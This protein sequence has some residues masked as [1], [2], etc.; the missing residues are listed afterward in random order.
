MIRFSAYPRRA[1]AGLF[2]RWARHNLKLLMLCCAGVVGLLAF[3]TA[4]MVLLVPA[5][6]FRW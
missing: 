6:G 3:Q 4:L 5:S 2:R 1:Y